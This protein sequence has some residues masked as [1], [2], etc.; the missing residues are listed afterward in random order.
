VKVRVYSP[1]VKATNC[2][3]FRNYQLVGMTKNPQYRGD[4]AELSFST[5]LVPGKNILTAYCFLGTAR[6]E[7]ATATI[8]CREQPAPVTRTAYIIAIGV[9][10]YADPNMK[11]FFA[12]AD[13]ELFT[14]E[15]AV[16]L[17]S[18]GNYSEVTPILMRDSESTEKNVGAVLDQLRG[19]R[20]PND[21]PEKFRFPTPHV[22]DAVYI[23]Y[24]GHGAFLNQHFNLLLQDFNR[25]KMTG[26]LSDTSLREALIGTQASDLIL[27]IDA[28]QSGKIIGD[29]DER[30]GPFDS[31][32]F[33]QTAYDKGVFMLL[34]TQSLESARELST[35]GHGLLTYSL[36][37]RGLE[38]KAQADVDPTDGIVTAREFLSFPISDVPVLQ[39]NLRMAIVEQTGRRE[40]DAP[41]LNMRGLT[42]DGEVP[43]SIQQPRTFIP[44]PWVNADFIVRKTK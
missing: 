13:A 16:S 21:V 34:A 35:Y 42:L 19:K 41:R 31:S 7:V 14:N 40:A 1:S 38:G 2:K 5:Q 11:L 24:A 6:T 18:T 22:Q 23:Y 20:L 27:I 33:A 28:C 12:R 25:D 30:Y 10:D 4:T 37:V 39:R 36:I 44:P 3:L 9:N 26:M 8:S 17:K 32:T 29:V 15:L 43:E